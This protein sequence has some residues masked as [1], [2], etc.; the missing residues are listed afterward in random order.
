MESTIG[1]KLPESKL[2]PKACMLVKNMTGLS[3]ADIQ[4]K[5][6]DNDYVITCEFTDTDGLAHMN[7]IKNKLKEM[8]VEVRQFQDDQ[9]EPSDYFDRLEKFHREID[10]EVMEG[11]D[12]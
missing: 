10:A 11:F 9:E 2:N 6:L 8:N 3:I 7:N 1:L 5:A 12:F 4:T